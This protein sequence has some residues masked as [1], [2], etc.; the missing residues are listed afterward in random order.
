MARYYAERASYYERVYFKP[1][2]QADLRRMEAELP[3]YF[4]GRRVLE[5]ACG[6]GWWTPHG[7]RD[8]ASWLATDLNDE[9]MEIARRKPLPPGKVRFQALDAYVLDALGDARF[10]AAFAGFWWSHVPLARL[11]AWLA[12]LHERLEPGARIVMLDNRFVPAS[13]L[14]ISRRDEDGNTYQLRTLDDG[15]TCEV[16]KNFPS[17]D[18]AIAALG[19][20]ARD[21][22]W[23]AHEHY[24]VLVYEL[25]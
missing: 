6:T 21:A 16:V 22:R 11:P 25:D 2:R 10:D 9:T 23:I 3:A 1:E 13:N 18:A 20:R 12:Q 17:A 8:C 7:A 15:S 24:W 14:P 19:P 5:I 4:T